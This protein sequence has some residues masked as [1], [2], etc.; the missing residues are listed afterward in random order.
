[1]K[2]CPFCAEEIQDAAIKCRHCGSDLGGSPSQTSAATITCPYC[3][4]TDVAESANVCPY[5]MGNL[6]LTKK[7]CFV[8]T[9]IMG[10]P[11]DP[12]VVTLREL[13]DSVLVTRPIGRAFVSAYERVGPAL[14]G[15]IASR[16]NL[17]RASRLILVRPAAFLSRAVLRRVR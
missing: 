15:V 8:A 3:K 6:V 17:R 12:A 2:K 5:C 1:M 9:A 13:R 11:D 7:V 4:K 10:S 16:P 14:A